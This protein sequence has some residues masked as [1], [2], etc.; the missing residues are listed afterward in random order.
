MTRKPD[1]IELFQRI[2]SKLPNVTTRVIVEQMV[3]ENKINFKRA[4][5]ILEKW[6]GQGIYEYGV[7]CLAGWL[8][9]EEL[10]ND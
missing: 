9:M 2:K 8:E 5:Y 7:S 3:M 1:E 6:S 4:I 10:P